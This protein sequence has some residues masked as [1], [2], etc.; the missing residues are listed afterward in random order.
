MPI[1]RVKWFS[2]EKGFGFVESDEGADVYLSASALPEG[3]ATV[4]P[5]TKLEFGIVEGKKGPQALTVRVIDEPASV[6]ANNR[7]SYDDLATMIED[8]IKILDKVGNGLRHGRYPANHE[9]ERLAK[10]LR[11]IAG[12]IEG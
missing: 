4:K 9:A 1:G 10:V 6:V 8:T 7:A 2:L 11:G 12:Q 5:G 3:V